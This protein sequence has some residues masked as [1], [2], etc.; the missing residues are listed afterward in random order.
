MLLLVLIRTSVA[1]QASR[2][3]KSVPTKKASHTIF[4]LESM[5]ANLKEQWCGY[6]KRSDL[7]A[8]IRAG[9]D[10][11]AV[12]EAT[13]T[14][15][16]IESI[17]LET[18]DD[19]GAGDWYAV[20]DYLLDAAGKVQKLNR[21]IRLPG[22]PAVKQVFL[23]QNGKAVKQRNTR[24]PQAGT[25]PIVDEDD[26]DLPDLPV[27]T[28]IREF[29]FGLLLSGKRAEILTKGKACALAPPVVEV[30]EPPLVVT[31]WKTYE[32][33][34][35]WTIEYPSQWTAYSSCPVGCP[36]PGEAVI[37]NHPNPKPIDDGVVIV[38]TT[39]DLKP[40][41]VDTQSWLSQIKHT[42]NVNPIVLETPTTI[43]GDPALTVRYE[44]AG[45]NQMETTYVV[46]G[47]LTFEIEISARKKIQDLPDYNACVH[48]LS[49]F[50]FP[51]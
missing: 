36:A 26:G 27:R 46:H 37:F 7:D 9:A 13:Y 44:Q 21:E 4:V 23:I 14:G 34:F 33:R 42:A 5:D 28:N 2:G 19:P 43:G 18:P 35:G 30:I 11:M 10:G 25:Q 41:S 3:A 8:A 17:H 15:I 49:T 47:N 45:G 12:G 38:S 22:P 51:K 29:P 31:S 1:Q 48:M 24:P 40:G 20:D 16:R 6:S 50:R 32:D 39:G